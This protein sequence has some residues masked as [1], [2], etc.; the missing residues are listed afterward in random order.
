MK[1]WLTIF[2]G[3][4]VVLGVSVIFYAS[5]FMSKGGHPPASGI[6]ALFTVLFITPFSI[7]C[8]VFSLFGATNYSYYK[9][10]IYFIFLGINV[11]YIIAVAQVWFYK[12]IL[13]RAI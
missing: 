5:A 8:L 13:G 3:M 11:F 1:Y 6:I 12:S 2:S 9:Q 7:L 4:L 10:R